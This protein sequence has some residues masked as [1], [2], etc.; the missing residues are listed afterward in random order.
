MIK[1]IKKM[2]AQKT[3]VNEKIEF[4]FESVL[5]ALLTCANEEFAIYD[6]NRLRRC[7]SRNCQQYDV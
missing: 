7:N 5:T 1:D 6:S 4:K 2:P 3:T